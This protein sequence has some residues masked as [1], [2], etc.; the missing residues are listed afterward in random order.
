VHL[1][2]GQLLSDCLYFPDGLDTQQWLIYYISRPLVGS[3]EPIKPAVARVPIESGAGPG[4][5]NGA[6]STSDPAEASN[7]VGTVKRDIKTFAELLI[8]FPMIARQMNEGLERIFKDFHDEADK[9]LPPAAKQKAPAMHRRRSSSTS[10]SSVHSGGSVLGGPTYTDNRRESFVDGSFANDEEDQLRRA[11]ESAV[12]AAIDLFQ[13]VD[14]QQL[15]LVGATTDL[16]GPVIERLIERY[17][18]EQVHDTAVFPRICDIHRSQDR[19]LESCIRQMMHVDIAQVGIDIEGGRGGKNRLATRLKVGIEQ[20]RNMKT[21]DGPQRMLEILLETQKLVAAAT[22]GPDGGSEKSSAMAMNADTLVSLLLVVV[23]RAHVTHLQ[24]RLASM[25]GF[26]FIDDVDGGEFGYALSTF[27]AVLSYLATDSGGLRAASRRNRRL[28]HAT[29][30]G[31][32][33][34]LQSILEPDDVSISDDPDSM[35]GSSNG[36]HSFD[37][38]ENGVDDAISEVTVN[39]PSSS[40]ISEGTTEVD[41]QSR[42]SPNLGHVFPFQRNT[43]PALGGRARPP[44]KVAI[45]LRSLNSDVSLHSRTNSRTSTINSATSAI[46]GDTSIEKLCQTQDASGNSVLMMAIEGGQVESLDYLLSLEEYFPFHGVLDDVGSDGQSL[47]SAAVQSANQQVVD[48]LVDYLVS[49]AT[50]SQIKE[51]LAR[52]DNMG[53]TAAHYLFEAPSL[54]SRFGVLLP[55][56]KKDRNGQTPLL[57]LCRSYDHPQYL[58]MVNEALTVAT[59]EQGDSLPLHMDNHVDNR[60][61]SLLH[62]VTDPYLALRILQ[63]CD[64]DPNASNDKSFTPLM[65]ASKFGRFDLVRA[66]FLDK[67]VDVRAKEYRGM[68]AVELAKDDEVRNRID[69]MVLVSNIPTP[70]G[71]VT[72]VVRSFFVED[73][74][75]RVIIKTAAR[76]GDGMIAVTTTRRSLADFD[77]LA[78]SLSIEHPASWLPSIFNF[79]SPFQIPSKPSRAALH[80]IQVRLDKFLEIMLT[81]STFATHEL[82]W[83]F[84]LVPELSLEQT[85]ARSLLKS[86]IRQEKIKEEYEPLADYQE[87]EMFVTFARDSIRPINIAAKQVLRKTNGLQNGL[88]DLSTAWELATKQLND[89]EFLPVPHQIGLSRYIRAIT[90]SESDPY[91]T[92]HSELSAIA[93]TILAILSSLSRPHA[94]ISSLQSHQKSRERFTGALRRATSTERSWPLGGL[95]EESRKQAQLDARQRL[96]GAEEKVRIAGCELRYTQQTV[97]GELAGWHDLHSKMMRRAVRE[98]AKRTVVRERDRLDGMKRALRVAKEAGASV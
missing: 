59:Q 30:I 25:R 39:R 54:I 85:A 40:R 43:Q 53:R 72:A 83:E 60:G 63:H 24:A 32:I 58:S 42:G 11:L 94:L 95:L 78:K 73:S 66:M 86:E 93:S 98:L 91:R 27:E 23:I 26:I 44:K 21:A 46:A 1:N 4:K 69:D 45:D 15:S 14:K 71:R 97:A 12:T 52:T 33:S 70:D 19:E 84:I 57:A 28:W 92:L 13:R 41:G 35:I 89:L 56:R 81:H 64:S 34:E 18:V 65:I 48:L 7:A 31:N 29:K 36:D 47:L 38:F 87:V 9:P 80:D 37:G 82:L 55:W 6:S 5:E 20:F 50:P 79:R 68:T 96:E 22:V 67:R 62:V 2:Q 75:I 76:S 88:S 3:F 8:Q 51:Y 49:M 61:N 10:Q 17:V 16:T 74:T 77:N 90:T